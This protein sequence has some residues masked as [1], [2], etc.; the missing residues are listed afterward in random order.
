MAYLLDTN[1]VSDLIRNPHGNA[2]RR[3]TQTGDAPV[4]TSI[5]V[6]AELRF[7]A[8]RRKSPRLTEQ[9]EKILGDLDVLPLETPADRHY[10]ILR[11]ALEAAGTPISQHDMLIA[12]HA[13][14]LGWTLVTGNER[15]FS[16]VKSLKI[17]NWL[18]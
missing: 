3:L 12:S 4:A 1:I 15:E 5:I 8:E 10:G 13:L 6:A 14:A 11:T 2:A 16:R 17:E 9:L 18:R 7:G